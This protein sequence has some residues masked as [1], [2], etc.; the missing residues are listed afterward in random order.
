MSTD[1]A[2]DYTAEDRE[3]VRGTL[4]GDVEAFGALVERYRQP[5]YACT[6]GILGNAHDAA[7]ATQETFLCLYRNLEQFDLERPL[8]PYLMT[9][10]VNCA[11]SLLRRQR[12]GRLAEHDEAVIAALPDQRPLPEHAHLRQ[13]RRQLL[14]DALADLP[15]MLRE[16]C[17]LF[18][19]Q[20]YSC[21]EAAGILRTTEGAVKVALHRARERLLAGP[22]KEWLCT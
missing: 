3:A 21:R 22:L 11:R 19:L 13:E 2:P 10:A 18:Y 16:V 4:R 1:S 14:R 5:V 9:I 15:A 7:D 6:C 8:R 17:V 12:H 20:G